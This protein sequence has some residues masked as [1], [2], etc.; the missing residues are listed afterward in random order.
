MGRPN[1]HNSDAPTCSHTR[2]TGSN[3]HPTEWDQLPDSGPWY[4]GHTHTNPYIR[5]HTNTNN[6]TSYLTT[7]LANKYPTTPALTITHTHPH[8]HLSTLILTLNPKL[9]PLTFAQC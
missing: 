6:H 1:H 7:T 8:T 5:T 3:V 9:P 4:H 2:D